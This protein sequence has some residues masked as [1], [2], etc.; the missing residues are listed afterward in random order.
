MKT[1]NPYINFSGRCQEALT[2]YEA[3][4]NGKTVMRQTYGQAPQ[5]VSG[6][7]PAHIMHAEF[8]AEGIY[9]MA[10]DGITGQP[11]TAMNQITL[12][13][14]FSNSDEQQAVFDALSENGTITMPLNETFWGAKFGTLTD[15]FGIQWMLNHQLVKK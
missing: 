13:I 10:T 5:P 15:Q 2:F 6:V 1:F 9:F 11:S 4:L 14:N 7:N 3:A 8:K 12:N